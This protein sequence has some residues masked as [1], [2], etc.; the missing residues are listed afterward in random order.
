MCKKERRVLLGKR[1][2]KVGKNW[3]TRVRDLPQVSVS[4]YWE[5]NTGF[6]Y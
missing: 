4:G 5:A 1:W 2:E 6:L 3:V